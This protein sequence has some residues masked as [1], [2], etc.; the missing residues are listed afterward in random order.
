MKTKIVKHPSNDGVSVSLH[1][2]QPKDEPFLFEVYAST[3]LNEMAAW[4]WDAAQQQAFLQMQFAAQ[5]RTYPLAP[6][7]NYYWIIRLNDRP[8]GRMIILRTDEEIRLASIV[9]LPE[10]QNAGIGTLLIQDLLAEA[11]A[12]GKPVWLH[13]LRSNVAAARLYERLGFVKIGEDDS[14]FQMEWRPHP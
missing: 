4:G 12:V 9:L 1:L 2:A 3:R 13:V 6:P 5:H 7:Q 10:Y 8:I 11:A 14:H